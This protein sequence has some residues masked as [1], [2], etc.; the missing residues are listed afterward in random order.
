MPYPGTFSVFIIQL[1]QFNNQTTIQLGTGLL[2]CGNWPKYE[3]WFFNKW[4]IIT[5]P[6]RKGEN[7]KKIIWFA[8]E[9][10][11]AIQNSEI[12][13][14]DIFYESWILWGLYDSL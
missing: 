9:K 7:M 6:K 1:S 11:G 8:T 4:K 12:L 3:L 14:A 2:N 13:N 5:Q 10:L